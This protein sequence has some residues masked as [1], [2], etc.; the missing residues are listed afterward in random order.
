M[1]KIWKWKWMPLD[2]NLNNMFKIIMIDLSI[3]LWKEEY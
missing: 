3:C 1:K 2:K